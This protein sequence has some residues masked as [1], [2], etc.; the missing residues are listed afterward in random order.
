MNKRRVEY[1]KIGSFF[2]ACIVFFIQWIIRGNILD[3]LCSTMFFISSVFNVKDL[4][5]KKDK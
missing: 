1:I 4:L 3:L 5:S 2:L